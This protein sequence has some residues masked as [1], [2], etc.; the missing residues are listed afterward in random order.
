MWG[1]VLWERFV[2]GNLEGTGSAQQAAEPCKGRDRRL[3]EDRNRDDEG[4]DC[5]TDLSEDKARVHGSTGLYS[6]YR[7]N[8]YR[9]RKGQDRGNKDPSRD[10]KDRHEVGHKGQEEARDV[11]ARS[12]VHHHE[13]KGKGK[14]GLLSFGLNI[15]QVS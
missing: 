2:S 13:D 6:T 3:L 4:L 15:H 5:N 1:V 7:G 12:R 10:N 9:D 14:A 11:H 8:K